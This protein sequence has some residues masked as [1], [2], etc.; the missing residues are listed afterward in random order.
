MVIEA[1]TG[2]S[3]LRMLQIIHV[4]ACGRLR[5]RACMC[6]VVFARLCCILPY[7]YPVSQA[8]QVAARRLM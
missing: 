5:V 6:P 8:I 3:L 2:G 7:S 1:N 4:C